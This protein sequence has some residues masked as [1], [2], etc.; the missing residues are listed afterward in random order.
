MIERNV[1]HAGPD[2]D[3][4]MVVATWWN[5][6]SQGIMFRDNWL[7][8]SG[9]TRFGYETGRSGGRY[10]ASPGFPPPLGIAFSGNVYAGGH[11]NIPPDENGKLREENV[12]RPE[13][14]DV[15]VFDPARPDDL[16]DFLDKHRDW[17]LDMLKRELSHSPVLEQPRI[18]APEEWRRR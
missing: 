1:I 12:S 3:V 8:T 13:K 10:I 7:G 15:P 5:G 16:P 14:W 18:T 11:A 2:E 6:W 17:M 4:Q 9:T